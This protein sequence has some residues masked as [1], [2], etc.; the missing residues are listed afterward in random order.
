MKNVTIGKLNDT[1]LLNYLMIYCKEVIKEYPEL[2]ITPRLGFI[3]RSIDMTR[4]KG[5][6]KH[7]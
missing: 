3:L 4:M 5:G 7:E 2:V 6:E 1:E